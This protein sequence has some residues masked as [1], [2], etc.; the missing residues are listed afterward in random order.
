MSKTMNLTKK[1]KEVVQYCLTSL[2][3]ILMS[4][5]DKGINKPTISGTINVA[6]ENVKITFE[7][8]AESLS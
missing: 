6:N 8:S 4:K 1:E 7:I 5:K 2:A 3:S